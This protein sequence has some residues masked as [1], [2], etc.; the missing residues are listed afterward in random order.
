MVEKR[1]SKRDHDWRRREKI[2]ERR[3]N[4]PNRERRRV[5][6]EVTK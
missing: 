5:K 4:N 3:G 2:Q 6:K 1:K